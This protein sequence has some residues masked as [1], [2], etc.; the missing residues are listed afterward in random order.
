MLE[1]S[2]GTGRN[3]DYYKA[4]KVDSVVF[5]D[6]SGPMLEQAA[7]KARRALDAKKIAWRAMEGD[8]ESLPFADAAFDTVVDTFG[9]CSMDNPVEALREMQ[10]VCKPDGTILLLEHGRGTWDFINSILD[11]SAERH[12]DNYGC[13]Y[14]RD[15]PSIVAASGL[16]IRARTRSHF[17][18][19]FYY[20]AS[21]GNWHPA[22]RDPSVLPLAPPSVVELAAPRD[23]A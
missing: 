17:G 14:N 22:A 5:L 23:R 10:R 18:T 15:I 4:D 1:V 19:T 8:C 20:V 11:R 2:V 7:A 9:L 6:R 21:P 13:W 16:A 3:M 12:A